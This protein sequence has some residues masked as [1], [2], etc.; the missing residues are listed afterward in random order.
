E[1]GDIYTIGREDGRAF[2]LHSGD[3]GKTYTA[4]EIPGNSSGSSFDIEQF[5]GHNIPKGP[6]PII[7]F[8]RSK[9]DEKHFWRRYGE[10]ELLLPVKE[11]GEIKWE[12]PLLISDQSLGFSSHSGIPSS[13]VSAGN[14]IFICWGEA[15]DPDV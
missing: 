4:Y 8:T 6:P 1:D 13:M 2:L 15:T 10:M 9:T 7:R 11:K 5:S 3:A 14:K 12:E